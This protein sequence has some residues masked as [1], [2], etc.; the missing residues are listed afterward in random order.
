MQW[1]CSCL[2]SMYNFSAASAS[3][4]ALGF[5]W[6]GQG[7]KERDASWRGVARQCVGIISWVAPICL[8]IVFSCSFSFFKMGFLPSYS[9]YIHTQLFRYLIAAF[10]SDHSVSQPIMVQ[11]RPGQS[12]HGNGDANSVLSP[13]SEGGGLGVSMVEYVLS[14]SPGDKMDGRSRNGGYVSRVSLPTQRK[15]GCSCLWNTRSQGWHIVLRTVFMNTGRRRC[16]PRWERKEWCPR[17]SVSLWRGQEPR[18]EGGR[19]EW[20]S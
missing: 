15:R 16:W 5:W 20:S 11:R 17:E 3:K 14:S 4:K 13:R 7:W 12:F 2:D 8:C 19:G 6:V 18:D 1:S 10:H 9:L